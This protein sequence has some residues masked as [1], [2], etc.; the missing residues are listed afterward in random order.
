MTSGA[1]LALDGRLG[2]LPMPTRPISLREALVPPI[3]ALSA[4]TA[5]AAVVVLIDPQSVVSYVRAH[6][7]LIAGVLGIATLSTALETA[8]VLSVRRDVPG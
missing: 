7:A 1:L 8:V 2:N 5:L 4:S 3:T 6:T